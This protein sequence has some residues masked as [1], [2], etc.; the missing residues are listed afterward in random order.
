MFEGLPLVGPG[1]ISIFFRKEMVLEKDTPVL[2]RLPA[3]GKP[4]SMLMLKASFSLQETDIWNQQ[5]KKVG[6]VKALN[7]QRKYFSI[8]YHRPKNKKKWVLMLGN[9]SLQNV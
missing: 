7:W 1:S 8:K 6:G 5:E 2:L 9:L 3:L 4:S